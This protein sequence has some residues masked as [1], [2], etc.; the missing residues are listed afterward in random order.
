MSKPASFSDNA[1]VLS[2][3]LSLDETNL[4]IAAG[5]LQPNATYHCYLALTHYFSSSKPS[6]LPRSITLEGR[7][8]RFNI[9][10]LN[11][12]GVFKISPLCVVASENASEAT[13]TVLRTQGSEGDVTV[14]YYSTDGTAVS[15]SNYGSVSGTLIFPSGVS[16]QTFTVPLVNDGV[17]SSP[18][19]AHFTLTNAMGGATLA[20]Q[21]H[22]V[23]TILDADS[24][25][26]PT[27]GSLLLAKAEF[28][29]QTNSTAP[30][31]FPL[32]VTSRF[33]ASVGPR[34]PGGVIE[35]TLRLPDGTTRGLSRIFENYGAFFDYSDD[36][37]S[38]AAL[39]KRFRSGKYELSV[40]TLSDGVFSTTLTLR[41]ERVFSVPHVTNW[42]DAQT[43]DPTMPFTLVWDPFAHVTT[44][45]YVR[46]ILKNETSEDVVYTPTEL[47]PGALR[48][49]TR[50]Y[51]IPANRLDYGRK[52]LLNVIFSKT[53]PMSAKTQ[54]NTPAAV[55]SVRTTELYIRTIPSPGT[56]TDNI[57]VSSAVNNTVELYPASGSGSVFAAT[58]LSNPEGI[59]YANGFIYIANWAGSTIYKFDSNG[60][61]TLFASTGLNE[62]IG[63][64]F[65]TN[66]NLYAANFG[67]NTIYKFDSNG[68]GTL[69][70]NS[71]L[72]GPYDL[73]F[74]SSG[75]LYVANGTGNTIEKFT[76]DGTP[77]VF[78][79]SGMSSPAGLVFDN[80]GYLY[81]ANA[82][83]NNILKFDSQGNGTLF[84]S[85]GL[86]NPIGLAFDSNGSLFAVNYND[87][88]IEKFDSS[89]NGT[90]F[91]NS[92]LSG[93]FMIVIVPGQ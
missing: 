90:P 72:N 67:D 85:S 73:T 46:V 28:Y 37:P 52:Y 65:D 35:A 86:N 5:T 48:G 79:S 4:T 27:V 76:P 31:Q 9:K 33:Y 14:D 50:S 20:T 82:G 51:T 56:P 47:A 39:N 64:A 53:I 88:S 70:A 19:T 10:T 87:N 1:G 3:S 54:A 77:S 84:T 41:T 62:P 49:S 92:G 26:G 78:A 18:L 93:P 17:S 34:F 69:F 91:G 21:P 60:N 6:A 22:A 12:A 11:P 68:N 43:I 74:D 44:N 38:P 71:G 45:D 24:P 83:L 75:N 29:Y 61:G 8:T 66:G 58:G 13:M 23:L 63:L 81:V 16:N 25:P 55:A 2:Q 7:I 32:A 36:F 40:A 42:A 59:A 15:K 57:Y 89:G 30:T 80:S